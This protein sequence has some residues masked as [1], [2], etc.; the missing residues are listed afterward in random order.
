MSHIHAHVH[1]ADALKRTGRALSIGIFINVAYA[2]V[3]FGV[4]LYYN[5]MG[6][7]ADAGHNLS[8]VAGLVLALIAMR[9]VVRRADSRHTFGY[10]KASVLIS[11]VNASILLA[12][13]AGIAVES[14]R[15]FF[16][17][18]QVEGLSVAVTAGLGVVVNFVSAWLLNADKGRDINVRGAYLH[19][20]L[21]AMVSIGVVVSGVVIYFT[22]WNVVDPIVGLVVAVAIVYSSW[23]LF[24]TSLRLSIDGVPDGVDVD[25]LV[26]VVPLDGRL[27]GAHIVVQA[28]AADV[29]ND[30]VHHADGLGAGGHIGLDLNGYGCF[31]D[32]IPP[33][34]KINKINAAHRAAFLTEQKIPTNSLRWHYPTGLKGQGQLVLP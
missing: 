4:G 15:R 20:V 29:V 24:R 6:L 33:K 21:D 31:H 30:L 27:A 17:P 10:K 12:A 3:E 16:H 32:D 2:A 26:Q 5:S 7:I 11:L 34:N 22:G 23:S 14:V 25:E 1:G 19:M 8:D 18:D 13:V 9:L 28:G